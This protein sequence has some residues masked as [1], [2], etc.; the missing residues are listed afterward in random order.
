VQGL[1]NAAALEEAPAPLAGAPA[2]GQYV[3]PRVMNLA[4]QSVTDAIALAST[5]KLL[6][7]AVGELLTNIVFPAMC[8]DDE[9]AELWRDDPQEYIRKARRGPGPGA[10][11]L[12]LPFCFIGAEAVPLQCA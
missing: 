10:M 8:F 9:D 7:P 3:S 4:L 2:Q 6:R 1:Y 11:L 5:W 12:C